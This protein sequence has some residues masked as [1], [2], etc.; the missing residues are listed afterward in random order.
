[1]SDFCVWITG[2][3]VFF[4]GLE[5]CALGERLLA[6]PPANGHWCLDVLGKPHYLYFFTFDRVLNPVDKGI[7]I[8]NIG[9]WLTCVKMLANTSTFLWLE[10]D[11]GDIYRLYLSATVQRWL[12]VG[13]AVD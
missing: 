12:K 10:D 2:P 11:V 9:Y 8:F 13:E 4:D 7:E 3:Q 1:M 5:G 6:S